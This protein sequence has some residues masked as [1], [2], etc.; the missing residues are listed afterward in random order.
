MYKAGDSSPVSLSLNKKPQKVGVFVDYEEG[1]VSFDDVEARSHIYSFTDQSFTEKLYPYLSH[2]SN[3]KGTHSAL[4]IIS[5]V[6]YK[7]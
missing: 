3:D 2:W 7:K 4:L 5:P 1:L 6:S